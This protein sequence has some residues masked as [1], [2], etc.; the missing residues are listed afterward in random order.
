MY[1]IFSYDQM[2]DGSQ[3]SALWY[4]GDELVHFE[5]IPWNGGSGGL[6]FSDWEPEPHEWLVG[7]Y[8]VQIFAGLTWKIS[9]VFTVTGDPPTPIPS[10]TPTPTNT[11][12][13][14]LTPTRTPWPTA[15]PVPTATPRP[16]RTPYISPTITP[17]PTPWPTSTR[18]PVTPSPTT[19][20]TQT[21]TPTPRPPSE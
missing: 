2:V 7:E 19:W 1:A 4:R 18:T 13:N 17:S 14:T 11:P 6:G 16:T 5:T 20:P 8:E 10:A 3:W 21:R 9:G 12:T 15:T